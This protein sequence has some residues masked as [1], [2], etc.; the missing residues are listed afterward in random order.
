MSGCCWQGLSCKGGGRAAS[1]PPGSC[2]HSWLQASMAGWHSGHG[3]RAGEGHRAQALVAQ[4][5]QM[6][7]AAEEEQGSQLGSCRQEGARMCRAG[8]F[9]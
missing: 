7:A 1:T 3:H 8:W 9:G 5:L 4:G 6:Q 2:A